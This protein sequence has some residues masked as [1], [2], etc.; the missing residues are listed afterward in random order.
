MK[1]VSELIEILG[2]D[3]WWLRRHRKSD[4]EPKDRLFMAQSNKMHHTYGRTPE[5][6]LDKL[7]IKL[8]K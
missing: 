4:C 1:T 2:K 8:N 5:E 6:A 3:L 7:R